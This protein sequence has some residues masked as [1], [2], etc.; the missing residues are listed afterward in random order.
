MR[1]RITIQNFSSTRDGSGQAVSSWVDLHSG[2]PANFYD[3]GGGTS[4]RGQ[5]LEEDV[6]AVFEVRF[7][8]GYSPKQRVVF[9]GSN[10][11]ITRVGRVNGGRRYLALYCRGVAA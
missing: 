9:E 10:Y 4:Y 2:E 5:Q 3:V 11:G 6:R 8:E 7:R 1:H